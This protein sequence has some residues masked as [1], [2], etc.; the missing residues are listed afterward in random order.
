MCKSDKHMISKLKKTI[1]KMGKK[2]SMQE[3]RIFNQKERISN[4][5]SEIQ[6]YKKMAQSSND[7]KR[8]YVDK[9]LNKGIGDDV[10]LYEMTGMDREEFEWILERFKKTVENSSETPRSSWNPDTTISFHTIC[11]GH[12]ST[13]SKWH[14]RSW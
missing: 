6:H 11:Y 9:Y 13:K 1:L 12:T 8:Q 7:D 5:E 3:K 4:Q 10:H 2:S 14:N